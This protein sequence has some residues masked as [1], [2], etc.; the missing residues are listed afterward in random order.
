MHNFII[1]V[2]WYFSIGGW[3]WIG[4]DDRFSG[5]QPIWLFLRGPRGYFIF[6]N[7][8]QSIVKVICNPVRHGRTN[9]PKLDAHVTFRN[10]HKIKLIY[11]Y[12]SSKMFKR[13]INFVWLVKFWLFYIRL[14]ACLITGHHVAYWEAVWVPLS[15]PDP[16]SFFKPT[17]KE[18]AQSQFLKLTSNQCHDI[19]T[20]CF[21]KISQQ[22]RCCSN[23][24]LNWLQ[25]G[26]RKPGPLTQKQK[27]GPRVHSLQLQP[28]DIKKRG[29]LGIYRCSPFRIK[30]R[31]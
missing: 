7:V 29:K 9:K 16:T 1:L 28:Q 17:R 15:R 6:S 18:K 3:N 2:H 22:E 8:F 23:Q 5:F 10:T 31:S 26:F 30:V 25:L 13:Y 19:S 12:E 11:E 24:S 14:P 4:S 20:C 21:L 27:P